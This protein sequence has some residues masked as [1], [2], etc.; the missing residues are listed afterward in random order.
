ML[1]FLVAATLSVMP[2]PECPVKLESSRAGG[3]AWTYRAR[4]TCPIGFDTTREAMRQLLGHAARE[5]SVQLHLGRIVD[6]PW[7]SA[8]LEKHGGRTDNL[9]VARSLKAMPELGH[10][11]PGWE[12]RSVSVEKV[13]VRNGRPYDAIMWVTLAR[14]P[15]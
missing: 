6:Y 3:G 7:L 9:A 1:E 12:V 8:L 4:P 15:T 11:F 14:L 2:A 10:L 5:S 13:L